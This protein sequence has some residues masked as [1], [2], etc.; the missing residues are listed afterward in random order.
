MTATY[1]ELSL[2]I[3]GE[4]IG[5]KGRDT[6]SVINP[7]TGEVLGELPLATAADLDRALEAAQA[8][9]EV[10]RRTSPYERSRILRK[11]ADLIRE[12]ADHIATQLTLEEGKTLAE[13]RVET[14][15]AAD[16]FEWYAEEGRRAYGRIVPTR[17]AGQ[18][19]LVL[20][21][22]VGVV[23]AFTPWNFPSLTPARK[24]AGALGAGCACILK[25]A[26]ETP[27]TA[28]ALVRA[29]AD[30][31]LPK[32]I[33]GLVFG[34]PAEVSTHLIGSPIVRKISF[35]GSTAVGKQLTK[36]AAEGMKRT[37]MELGGHAPVIVLDD[38]DA[39]KAATASVTFKYRNAGQVCIA[40][41]RFYVHE[42]LHERFVDTFTGLAEG[43][44]VGNGLDDGIQMGPLANKRR[45]EAMDTLIADA[46]QHGA[47]LR[48]GGE[49]IGNAGH[50]YKPTV[51]AD[52]PISARIMNEEPFGP[53][54]IINRFGN[55]DDMI[56]E[57]NRL[58]YGLASYAFTEAQRNVSA[59]A[60]SV[61]AGMLGINNFF[62][63]VP[64]SPFGGVKESGHGSEGGIEGLDAYLSTKLVSQM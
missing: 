10:W 15:A 47:T 23:A 64:E 20:R 8:G 31:G 48:T 44:R 41:T 60:E 14:I 35:T 26:E 30:A 52:V 27:S 50:F 9:F 46:R 36:L 32:G 43:L 56:K 21:E 1:D 55:F 5:A 2:F 28:I 62:V 42:S 6:K 4:W 39:I 3:A 57:A 13:A 34:D 17:L 29:L 37:T 7:A 54:A 18:R 49:R 11:A 19:H 59:L 51:L 12:R 40:P 38:A 24:I 45:I 33:L 25:A 22:P 61:E 53:V 63:S 58:P 16:T